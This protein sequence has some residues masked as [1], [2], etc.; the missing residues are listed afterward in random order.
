MMW[1]GFIVA[2]I[3]AGLVG[4]FSAPLEADDTCVYEFSKGTGADHVSWCVSSGGNIVKFRAQ[5]AD[6]IGTVG[7]F[8]E[9]F[10]FCQFPGGVRLA[11][12]DGIDQSGWNGQPP[13]LVSLSPLT[14]DR[15]IVSPTTS[16]PILRFRQKFTTDYAEKE[17]LVDMTL[18]NISTAEISFLTFKRVS[19]LHPG[20][21]LNNPW[22]HG[23][24]GIF[25]GSQSGAVTM[26][27]VIKNTA[28]SEAYLTGFSEVSEC[29]DER[30]AA[31]I[32]GDLVG[33]INYSVGTL[34]AGRGKTFRTMYRP[35]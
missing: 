28:S 14:I 2:L 19:N 21:Q 22:N 1:R 33:T 5:G 34:K 13:T 29:F 16:Q 30:V 12:D 26:S 20:G 15:I 6:H 27:S 25:V 8:T 32:Q 24:G 18:T 7:A 4:A 31:P 35:M 11:Y 23:V 10:T 17:L 9:G 3:G